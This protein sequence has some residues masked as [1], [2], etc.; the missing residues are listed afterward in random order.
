MMI[1]YARELER[2]VWKVWEWTEL[3]C[4]HTSLAFIKQPTQP[5]DLT[6]PHGLSDRLRLNVCVTVNNLVANG[7]FQTNWLMAAETKKFKR[8]TANFTRRMGQATRQR[9]CVES[10]RRPWLFS[11]KSGN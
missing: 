6:M 11:R 10:V 4:L 5:N 8:E 9:D 2:I 3:V 7:T 1:G